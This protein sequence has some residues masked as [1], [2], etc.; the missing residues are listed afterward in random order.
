MG[1]YEPTDK[2]CEWKDDDDDDS[3][4]K[5]KK[6]GDNAVSGLTVSTTGQ[7]GTTCN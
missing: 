4:D 1:T 7:V 6:D 5:N 2:E 3:S